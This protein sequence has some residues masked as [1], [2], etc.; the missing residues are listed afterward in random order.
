MLLTREEIEQRI[1]IKNR[2]GYNKYVS[3]VHDK[4]CISN[5]QGKD[6]LFNNGAGTTISG[7]E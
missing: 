1:R 3:L 2:Y 4:D 5:H 7:K 6:G